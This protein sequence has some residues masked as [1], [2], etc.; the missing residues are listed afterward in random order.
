ML[1]LAHFAQNLRQI[2]ISHTS[3]T[4]LGLLS[5]ASIGCLQSMTVLHLKGLTPN[6]LAAALFACGGLRKVKLHASFKSCFAY[7]LFEHFETRGCVFEWRDKEFQVLNF[8]IN[9]F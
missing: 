9:P 5:L 6:G 7:N 1:P 4:D 3:V 8:Q 2:N